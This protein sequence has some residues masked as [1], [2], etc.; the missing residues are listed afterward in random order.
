MRRERRQ[1]GIRPRATILIVGEGERT[2]PH[3]FEGLKK[4]VEARGGLT[5]RVK[6]G[7]GRSAEDV[8]NEALNEMGLR[9]YDEVWCVIDVEGPGHTGPLQRARELAEKHRITLCMSN[10]SFEVWILAHFER[11]RKHFPDAAAVIAEINKHWQKA[12]PGQKY[13]K[14]DAAL[15][16][17][18]RDQRDAAISNARSV[19]ES[20]HPGVHDTA[21]ANSSTDVYRL[22]SRLLNG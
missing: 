22:V 18:L 10:P 14:G 12:F 21:K 7:R 20:D 11:T 15:F 19:R 9:A 4:A 5:V 8:V 6:K 13:E 16:E 3:Y 1:L 17:R 2:E